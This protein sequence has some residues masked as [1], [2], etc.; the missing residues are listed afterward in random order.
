VIENGIREDLFSPGPRDNAVR[1]EYGWRDEF[2]AMYVGAHGV[3]QGLFTLL[4]AAECLCDRD[5]IRFVFVGD[6]ADKPGMIEWAN[7]R[8][9]AN[10][11]FLPLQPKERM[12]ELYA[13][14]DAC[15]VPLRK[16]N[17]FTINIPS[18]IFEIMA[19]AR[20]IILGATGQALRIVEA[21]GCAIPVTPEVPADYADAVLHLHSAPELCRQLGSSGRAY[22]VEHFTRRQKAAHYIRVLESVVNCTGT[23][24]AG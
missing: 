5:E 7:E 22:V 8:G 21:A 12:P 2:V 14:A 6:G 15:F 19:C 3:S 1:E 9:L 18:K 24:D 4:D 10:V 13:A 23:R 20:P 16:G 11:E 17:Y